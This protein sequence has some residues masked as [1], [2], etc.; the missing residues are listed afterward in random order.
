M[1]RTS[2]LH[3]NIGASPYFAHGS[4]LYVD[5]ENDRVVTSPSDLGSWAAC[6]WSFLRGLDSKLGRIKPVVDPPDAMLERTAALGIEHEQRYLE[7][8][9]ERYG[10]DGVA[11]F[12]DRPGRGEYAAAAEAAR[13]KMLER[14]PVV[15]QATFFDGWFLGF[16]DFLI[17]NET[18]EYEVYDTK[19]ARHA[20]ISA[21]LQLAGYA[22][23]IAALGI[24]VGDKVHL[25]LG[26]DT[27]SS[28]DLADIQ[29]VYDVQLARL[30]E[31][32]ADRL[33]AADALKWGDPRFSACGR[34]AQC[35]VEVEASRDLVLVAGMRLE[36]RS[37][38]HAAG[39]NTIDKLSKHVGPVTGISTQVL[40]RMRRQAAAQLSS[41]ADKPSVEVVA[42]NALRAIPTPDAGDIFFDFEGDPLYTEDSRVWGLDYLFGL[43]END[44]EFVPFW[45]HTF[46]EER[47]A[48]IDFLDYVRTRRAD[49]PGMHIYHYASYEK[50]HLLSLAARHGVGED[51]I[52]DLLRQNVL[53]DL[54][55][56]VK[57]ALV[58]GSRSYS[59]KKLE[60]LYMNTT[61]A[62]DEVANAVDSIAAYAVAIEELR[63]GDPKRGR[64]LLDEVEAYNR[65]D[66]ESTLELRDWLLRLR[67]G[68]ELDAGA[69][70]DSEVEAEPLEV[71][72]PLAPDPTFVALMKTI[73]GIDP[74]DRTA[75]QTAVA[76]AASAIDYHRREAKK[77]WQEHFNRLEADIDDFADERDVF[78]VE[79]ASVETNWVAPSGTAKLWSR[80]L[81]LTLRPAPASRLSVGAKPR[82]LYDF[83][84]PPG[85]KRS[86]PASRGA[87][88]SLEILSTAEGAGHS[89]I[90]VAKERRP[91]GVED[92]WDDLPVALTPGPPI[93]T[94]SLSDAIAGWGAWLLE[95]GL[96]GSGMPNDPILDL[97]RRVPPRATIQAIQHGDTVDAVVSTL[98][99]SENTYL[100]IQGPP[101]TGKTYV[102]SRV[103]AR[104]VEE[105]GWR[106]GVVAQSHSAVEHFLDAVVEAGLST[107]KVGKVPRDPKTFTSDWT[108]LTKGKS[109]SA[110]LANEGGLVFGGT[111]W[112][113]AGKLVGRRS[114]DLLVVEEAGQFS[115]APTI[116]AAVSA[117]RLL[118]LGDP[119]QLPQ[120]SQGTHPEPVDESALGWLADGHEILPQQFGYF[121]EETRRMGVALCAP[122][123]ELSYAGRL[124]SAASERKLEGIEPGLHI[125][126]VE[127]QANTNFSSEE[128]ARVVEIA[129][130]VVG[131]T[132]HDGPGDV[133][134][135]QLQP[136]D[137]IV[138]APY[139]AQVNLIRDALD[140]VGLLD[141]RVGTVD[142]FQGREGVVSIVSLAASSGEDIPR[143][144]DFLLQANRLNVALSRAQWAAYLISSPRL[145]T[146]R[147]R[148]IPEMRLLSRY[149]RL[150]GGNV[151]ATP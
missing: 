48:L 117:E 108:S 24:P 19:L 51:E 56:I 121:L 97:L 93:N 39:I 6:E 43:V 18:G 83:P 52:D 37:R 114:L 147:P 116:A 148:S 92:N 73:E 110:F 71:P 79:H 42:P 22:K 144:L 143:G 57:Q 146:G 145:R 142:M 21:L 138:V 27:T 103:I 75:D 31:V 137:V 58:V 141:T 25:V 10:A 70:G 99:S 107:A 9:R 16:S 100:G 53:V 13:S 45:A 126:P 61:R 85:L 95:Q 113:F 67:A 89:I 55:P 94:K 91:T 119:Q 35:A 82:A 59:I 1:L 49:Y 139:N 109:E 96:D 65:Y 104:L 30:R 47:Q 38:L 127:H 87:N 74:A 134:G 34:C 123:S 5:T 40:A 133:D 128:A 20:K 125:V 3:D 140:V 77:S 33:S 28:H 81:R 80:T 41:S 112:A 4:H 78:V 64:E 7:V 12:P 68:A 105:C 115:L 135:R 2:R 11:E 8:L 90:A 124:R 54:Y 102:G 63:S 50:T 26:N 14:V 122:V 101:G 46:A 129:L 149:I 36:Q 17:L 136:R 86:R 150:T 72:V 29:P 106:I 60:P 88:D 76:I 15:Y 84:P 32:L 62:N 66:C 69:G 118:L 23:Q 130:E 120:V 111:A 131:S 151:G 132:W 44:K 98:R